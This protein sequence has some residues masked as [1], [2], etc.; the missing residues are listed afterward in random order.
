MVHNGTM[1][2]DDK[3]NNPNAKRPNPKYLG[4]RWISW[5]KDA[6]RVAKWIK[7]C[8][9]ENLKAA[10]DECTNIPVVHWHDF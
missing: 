2:N 3:Y 5:P 10:G 6:S 4:T 1:V 8:N 7:A 9:T